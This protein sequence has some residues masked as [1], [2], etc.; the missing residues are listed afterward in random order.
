MFSRSPPGVASRVSPSSLN[1]SGAV[2]MRLVAVPHRLGD[3]LDRCCFMSI[4]SRRTRITPRCGR[5]TISSTSIVTRI[6]ASEGTP[7]VTSTPTPTLPRVM[8]MALVSAIAL[9]SAICLASFVLSFAALWDL[10]TQAGQPRGLV[11]PAHH[12]R[13]DQERRG[14]RAGGVLELHPGCLAS[15]ARR[16]MHDAA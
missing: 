13:R 4:T 7:P 2:R 10:A 6:C 5:P 9:T 8:R 12:D 3:Q 16:R 15:R 14:N 1:A 11:R